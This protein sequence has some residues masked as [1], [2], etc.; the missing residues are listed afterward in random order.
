MKWL[1]LGLFLCAWTPIIKVHDSTDKIDQEFNG[2]ENDLQSKQFTV[3]PST[4]NLLDLKDGEMVI[5]S[6]NTAYTRL[7][8][9]Y[10]QEIWMVNASCVTVRR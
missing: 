2:Q 1:I 3:V 10:N 4:P 5:V 7:M 8:F 9:R 6:T